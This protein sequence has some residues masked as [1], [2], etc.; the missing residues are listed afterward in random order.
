MEVNYTIW[1][2]QKLK[3]EIDVEGITY[4][5]RTE[6]V[7]RFFNRHH[8]SIFIAHNAVF[9]L[10]VIMPFLGQ[11]RIY[12]LID[13]K[14]IRCTKLLYILYKLALEGVADAKSSLKNVVKEFYNVDLEKGQE[15]VTFGQYLGKP[16]EDISKSHIEYACLDVVYTFKV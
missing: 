1:D 6:D 5:V 11:E 10:D 8:D 4:L 2:G 15:R 16:I 9:D 14:Q 12:E 13:N 7:R 3:K